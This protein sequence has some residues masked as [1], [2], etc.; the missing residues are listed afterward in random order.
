MPTQGSRREVESK[1]GIGAKGNRRPCPEW[2]HLSPSLYL[3]GEGLLCHDLRRRRGGGGAQKS[4]F[5]PSL[6]LPRTGGGSS[7]DLI[8]VEEGVKVVKLC[9]LQLDVG[10]ATTRSN[11]HE[12]GCSPDHHGTF[13]SLLVIDFVGLFWYAGRVIFGLETLELELSILG[14][15]RNDLVEVELTS[16]QKLAPEEHR[17]KTPSMWSDP[18]YSLSG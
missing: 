16:R 3:G 18:S 9:L 4:S 17:L 1:G 14:V 13:P 5:L 6:P 8:P 2:W 15:V 11:H 7:H 10:R 12:Q